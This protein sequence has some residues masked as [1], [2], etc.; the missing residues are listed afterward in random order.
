MSDQAQTNQSNT[1]APA[2][3]KEE[4]KWARRA[5]TAG[6]WTGLGVLAAGIGAAA[7]FGVQAYSNSR[8]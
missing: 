5:K 4:S 2:P 7:Y 3:A 6:K 8:S 1:T